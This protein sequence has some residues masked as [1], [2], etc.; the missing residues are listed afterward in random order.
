MGFFCI[1]LPFDFSLLSASAKGPKMVKFQNGQTLMA[2]R[3][4]G[5]VPKDSTDGSCGKLQDEIRDR[6]PAMYHGHTGDMW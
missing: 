3:R 6:D 2:M 4:K 1:N 5:D